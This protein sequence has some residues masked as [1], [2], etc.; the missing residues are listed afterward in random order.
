M[1][2]WALLHAKR[3]DN[4]KEKEMLV[5]KYPSTA[6]ARLHEYVAVSSTDC[7]VSSDYKLFAIVRF[8]DLE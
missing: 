5:S 7:T 8:S 1:Y 6:I 2:N 4:E 3:S